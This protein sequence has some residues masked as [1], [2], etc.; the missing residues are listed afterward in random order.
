[1]KGKKGKAQR[2]GCDTRLVASRTRRTAVMATR[3]AQV[4][5]RRK[6][7]QA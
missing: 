6:K 3:T 7:K 1:M 4:S 5:A 2:K